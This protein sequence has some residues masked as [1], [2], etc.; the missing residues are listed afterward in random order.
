MN[1]DE[2]IKIL[3]YSEEK[4]IPEKY[5][6]KELGFP[7]KSLY[8][9]KRKYNMD[10]NEMGRAKFTARKVKEYYCNENFFETPN[11]INCYYAGFIAADGNISKDN[12]VLSFGLSIKDVSILE[13]LK[14]HI[15]SNTKIRYGIIR[16]KFKYCTL[17]ISSEKICSDLYKNFN[18]T[19][20]KSLTLIPPNIS[21]KNLIDSFICG[22]IDGDGSIFIS[23]N[24]SRKRESI[25]I[26]MLGTKEILMWIKK[27]FEEILNNTTGNLLHK[28]EHADNT[29]SYKIADKKGREIFKHFY[30]IDVPKLYRKWSKEY[31]DYCCNFIKNKPISKRK[32][33]NVFNL[34]GEFISHFDTLEEASEFTK[35]SC[36]RISNLCKLN[37]NEHMA[38]GF[39]FSRTTNN[40]EAYMPKKSTNIKY[41]ERNE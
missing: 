25:N 1:K 27:R 11:L 30:Q 23:S 12:K 17:C 32:G 26:S 4:Q 3:E 13:N 22:Y 31:N 20:R 18:I 39:M 19:P 5:A 29:F 16:N 15:E 35:V 14:S 36:G 37:D 7:C 38:N 28:K 40:M 2:L 6:A 8:Y 33:V 21:D 41:K 10:V 34:N 9:Y 24:K